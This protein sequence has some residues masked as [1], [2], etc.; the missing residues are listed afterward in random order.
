MY[1]Q[2]A[3]H[4]AFALSAMK[5]LPKKT[6]RTYRGMRMTLAAFENTYKVDSVIT[7]DAFVSQSTSQATADGFAQGGGTVPIKPDQTTHVLVTMQVFEAR[8]IK[9]MSVHKK[10]NEW[11]ML[12]GAS[13]RIDSIEAPANGPKGSAGVPEAT[14]WRY[15][16]MTQIKAT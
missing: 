11:T 14:A 8:D 13:Y 15:V 2:G 7:D 4:A 10:E 12:P 9:A 6:G 3:L 1:E 5:K 16:H